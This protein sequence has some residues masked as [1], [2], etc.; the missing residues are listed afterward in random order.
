[1]IKMNLFNI[2]FT[3]LLFENVILNKFLGICPFVGT[4]KNEKT[5]LGMSA[6]VTLVM[7][8]GSVATYYIYNKLLVPY[9][10][11]YLKIIVFI[12]LI[13]SLVQITEI[14][15]KKTSKA[16]AQSLGIFLPLITTNCAVLGVVLLSATN[17]YSLIQTISY[18]LGSALGF[19]LILYIFS[20]LRERIDKSE[21]PKSFKGLPIALITA[22]LMALIFSR[23]Q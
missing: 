6:S 18:A 4:T 3:A 12:L 17:E 8:I 11:E 14:I 19:T 22:A 7:L 2:F 10:I 5:A 13:A 9:N 16:L 21:I 15:I 23:Y 1:M 20:T